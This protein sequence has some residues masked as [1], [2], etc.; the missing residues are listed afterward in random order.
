MKVN[1][2]L[3]SVICIT[4][5]GRP[6]TAQAP[7]ARH[8]DWSVLVQEAG[9]ARNCFAASRPK[10]TEPKAA[11][12]DGAVFYVTA[13]PKDGIKSEASIRQGYR[14]KAGSEVL[15]AIGNETFRLF[16]ADDRA[17][18]GDPIA[19]LKLIEAMKK[20]SKMVVTGTAVDGTTTVDTYSLAG[21]KQA[22]QA[23]L[24]ACQ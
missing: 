18:I 17:F 5:C 12:R 3:V 14:G 8:G 16:V 13:W 21:I 10:T 24:A 6:A 1:V 2:A 15:V 9:G 19:E 23:M 11:A 22:L 7:T 20:G 4:L